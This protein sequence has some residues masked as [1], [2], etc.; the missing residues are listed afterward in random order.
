MNQQEIEW[1]QDIEVTVQRLKNTGTVDD[2]FS[3]NYTLKKNDIEDGKEF[4]PS[5]AEAQT[6]PKLKLTIT[7]EGNT[8]KYSFKI[9]GLEKAGA[10]GD[11][12]Y[13]VKETNIQ[14]EGYKAPS[15]SSPSAPTRGEA[16]Y[17]KGTI[18]NKQVGGYVLPQTGGIGTALFTALGGLMTATAGAVLALR[19][20]RKTA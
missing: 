17:D 10:D 15:Y 19:R 4:T 18:V 11:Y 2:S 13:F 6:G 5:G 12:A 14:L 8:K 3:L 7:T 16:A 1:D 9:E 20:K